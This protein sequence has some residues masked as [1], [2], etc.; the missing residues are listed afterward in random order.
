MPLRTGRLRSRISEIRDAIRDRA[1]R[2]VA[3]TH[4][5]HLGVTAALERVLDEAGDVG[6]VFDHED[7]RS[8]RNRH[9]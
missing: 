4:D 5:F 7:A 6:F 3:G 1:Q 2:R 9:G 8:R